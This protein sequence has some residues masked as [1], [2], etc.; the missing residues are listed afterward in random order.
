VIVDESGRYQGLAPWFDTDLLREMLRRYNEYP[1]L[2]GFV[3]DWARMPAGSGA[4]VESVCAEAALALA[5]AHSLAAFVDPGT[6][7]DESR[8]SANAGRRKADREEDADRWPPTGPEP[9]GPD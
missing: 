7:A 3:R 5:M 8:L 9:S 6:P 2:E 4:T 1:A